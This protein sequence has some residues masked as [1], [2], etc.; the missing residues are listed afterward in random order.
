LRSRKI[1]MLDQERKHFDAHRAERLA[2]YP[3]KLAL[4]KGAELIGAF[5]ILDEARAE[6]ARRF[7]FVSFL[8]RRVEQAE[9]EANIPALALG[10]LNANPTHANS[11]S[12]SN[13]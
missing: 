2:K 9:E 3:G 6:G 7:G 1:E 5:D 13:S 10:I 11:G 12:E 8:V 4:V